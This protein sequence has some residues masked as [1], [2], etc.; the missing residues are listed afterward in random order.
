MRTHSIGLPDA[1][2]SRIG[3]SS[4][5]SVFTSWWQFMQVS[6]GGTIARGA[7]STLTWQYRQSR[8]S[9]PT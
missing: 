7:R 4:C 3:C 5:E 6:V 2:L 8:P 1:Q 9:W